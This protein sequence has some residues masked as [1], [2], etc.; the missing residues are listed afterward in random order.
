MNTP[1]EATR[2]LLALL[3]CQLLLPIAASAYSV[4]VRWGASSNSS[5]AG[6][7]LYVRESDAEYG[8]PRTVDPTP[9]A[10]GGLTAVDR[11]SVV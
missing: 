8:A 7:H 4:K 9:D 5:I 6:Y 10:D 2:V 11:K 1:R 3:T